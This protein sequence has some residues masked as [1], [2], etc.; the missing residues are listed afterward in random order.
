MDLLIARILDGTANGV[1]YGFVGL[2]LV[3]VYRGSGYLNFAQGE[4]AMFSAY[5]AWALH[6]AGVPVLPAALIVIAGAFAVG[7]AMER[8]LIRPLGKDAEYGVIIVTIG[9]FLA[10]NA[11]ASAIWSPDPL[12]FTSLVPNQPG[13]FVSIFG[14]RVQYD[15]ILMLVVLLTVLFILFALFKFTKLGLAMR[16]AASNPDAGV[17]LGIR[18]NRINGLGWALA[19]AIGGTAAILVAPSTSLTPSFMFNFLIYGAAAAMLGGFDSPGGAVLSGIIL[20]I[21]ENLVAS[22]AQFIGSDLKQGFAL[23]VILAVLMVRPSGLFGSAR[24]ERV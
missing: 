4:M 24:I 6:A 21:G 2:S 13:D 19:A 23:V 14:K 15:E 11:A 17:L 9:L 7:M 18:V 12:R 10:I 1:V 3:I 8:V 5:C 22:Y 20:G 16:V